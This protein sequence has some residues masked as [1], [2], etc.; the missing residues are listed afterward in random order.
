M[1]FWVWNFIGWRCGWKNLKRVET[2]WTQSSRLHLDSTR[3]FQYVFIHLPRST[4]WYK[5]TLK[6]WNLRI[7]LRKKLN[8]QW[9]FFLLLQ[10]RSFSLFRLWFTIVKYG[11]LFVEQWWVFVGFRNLQQ[12]SGD[13]KSPRLARLTANPNSSR[14]PRNIYNRPFSNLKSIN[15]DHGTTHLNHIGLGK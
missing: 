15:M 7:Q 8:R 2:G 6:P 14:K 3:C 13:Q 11:H 1:T 12:N 9:I 4:F 5:L 10:R